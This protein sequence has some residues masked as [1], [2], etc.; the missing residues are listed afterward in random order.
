MVSLDHS[1][2]CCLAESFRGRSKQPVLI[3]FLKH[4]TVS[5]LEQTTNFN[6][7]TA[8]PGYPAEPQQ[9][10]RLNAGHDSTN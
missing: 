6:C 4:G 1:C 2:Q 5:C 7:F 10:A 9:A 3:L 8:A